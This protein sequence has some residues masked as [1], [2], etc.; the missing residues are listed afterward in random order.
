MGSEMR[1]IKHISKKTYAT[2]AGDWAGSAGGGLVI[3]QKASYEMET[4]TS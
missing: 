2:D 3:Y 4:R 1:L